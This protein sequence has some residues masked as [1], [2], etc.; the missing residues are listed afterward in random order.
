MNRLKNGDAASALNWSEKL[1]KSMFSKDLGYLESG[2]IKMISGDF[3]GSRADFAT[4]IDK[5]L[6]E[7][8][9]GPAIR[10]G[11]VG[12]TIAASTVA[13]DTIRQYQI[14]PYEIIQLLHY[15]TLNYLFSGDPQGASVE[16]RRTVFAQD[17]I[18]EKFP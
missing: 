4:A 17:A 8:E 7:T 12:S 1:K 13:D 11:S 16:M 2:R 6:E 3:A 18:A 9:N 15:Q 10:V 14:S 5:V